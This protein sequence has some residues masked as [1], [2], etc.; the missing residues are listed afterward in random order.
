MPKLK[1]HSGTKKRVRITKTGKLM[2]RH[3][4]LNHFLEKKSQSRKRRL[5]RSGT[6]TGKQA[7]SIKRKLGI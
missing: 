5:A 2:H 4:R 3:T 1:T 7:K 6:L